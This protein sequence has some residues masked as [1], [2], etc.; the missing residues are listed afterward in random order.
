MKIRNWCTAAF[1]LSALGVF[2]VLG[3]FYAAPQAYA[4]PP[5]HSRS[6]APAASITFPFPSKICLLSVTNEC[7]VSHGAGNRVTIDTSNYAIFHTLHVESNDVQLENAAGNC[8]REFADASVGLANGGCDSTNPHEFWVVVTSG[9]RTTFKN[10]S[11][12]DFL[13][14]F[15]TNSGTDVFGGPPESGFFTGWTS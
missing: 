8:L 6:A 14:T 4:Q 10:G 1:G 7:I 12:G 3:S 15:G 5:T 13:G 2:S 9:S 11:S